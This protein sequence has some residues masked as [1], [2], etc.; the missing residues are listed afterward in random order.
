MSQH[1]DGIRFRVFE[2]LLKIRSRLGQ[3]ES[4]D[5]TALPACE[6]QLVA[7][8]CAHGHRVNPQK[9]RQGLLRDPELSPKRCDRS[10]ILGLTSVLG[11]SRHLARRSLH[12]LFREHIEVH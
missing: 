8:P 4:R 11:G 2:P 12:K 9:P 1:E 10:R 7:L 3:K 6:S 5:Q